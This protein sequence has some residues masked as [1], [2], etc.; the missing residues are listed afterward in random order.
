MYPILGKRKQST[1]FFRVYQRGENTPKPVLSRAPWPPIFVLLLI[2]K[3]ELVMEIEVANAFVENQMVT[4]GWG[5]LL[6]V[7]FFYADKYV[8]GF[9]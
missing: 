6:L 9:K 5:A 4:L 2:I 1:H 8:Y 3:N 7:V